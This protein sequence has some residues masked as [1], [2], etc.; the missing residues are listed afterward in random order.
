MNVLSLFDGMSCGQQ[1]LE[2]A[3]FKVDNYFASEIKTHAIE[4]TNLH[5][6]NTIQLGSVLSLDTSLLPNI[7][8]L[9][10]GSPCQSFSFAGKMNGMIT[11]DNYEITNLEDY[12]YLKNSG[13]KFSGQSYLFWEYIRVLNEVKPKFFLLENVLM[14]KKWQ[15]IITKTLNVEPV[16]I[17]SAD[18]TAQTRKRNYWTNLP[19]LEYDKKD[20]FISDILDNNVSEGNK[21]QNFYDA[22]ILDA[23]IDSNV[24]KLK[25]KEATKKGFVL[26]SDSDGIDLSFPTSKTRRGRLMKSK[27]N[28]LLRT[29]EYYIFKDGVLRKFTQNELEKL[30]GIKA[31]YTQTLP[32][33]KAEDLIGDGWTVDV[34]AH[35]L[36]S[37]K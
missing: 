12:L 7:D 25:V 14:E 23:V 29:N 5:Y 2:R 36:K 16:M 26:V 28:C 31:G 3:G 11:T 24:I 15:N 30:Q 32:R 21:L 9:I 20:I 4:L 13:F 8:L 1:A 35:I 34:I 22:G 17:D 18:F 19:I 6:P 33:N 10:G 27:S 37:I